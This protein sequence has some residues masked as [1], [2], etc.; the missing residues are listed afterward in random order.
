MRRVRSY[1]QATSAPPDVIEGLSK[2]E[3]QL[4]KDK[5]KATKQ[6][7]ID[8][9]FTPVTQQQPKI[10]HF[11]KIA[12]PSAPPVVDISDE[13]TSTAA[14]ADTNNNSSTN[15][16][17]PAVASAVDASVAADTN[18]NSS[19]GLHPSGPSNDPEDAM[20]KTWATKKKP[21]KLHQLQAPTTPRVTRSRM[22]M[23]GP[24]SIPQ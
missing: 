18:N 7:K 9:F 4:L 21:Q 19:D 24:M 13:A 17:A 5:T 8:T 11:F 6:S 23:S 3:R 15:A 1:L 2:V 10:N 12:E 22:G 20:L 14:V 16:T